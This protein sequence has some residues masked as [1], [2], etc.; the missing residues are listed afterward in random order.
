M[1][2]QIRF[3]YVV[4]LGFSILFEWVRAA[5]SMSSGWGWVVAGDEIMM[6][7]SHTTVVASIELFFGFFHTRKVL[8]VHSLQLQ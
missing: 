2:L 5:Q 1:S 6:M 3:D 4:V 8:L 7:M